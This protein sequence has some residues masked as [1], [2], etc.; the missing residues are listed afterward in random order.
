MKKP[1]YLLEMQ[2]TILNASDSYVDT[3]DYSKTFTEEDWEKIA[4]VDDVCEIANKTIC[5]KYGHTVVDDQCCKPEHRYC[6]FCKASLP[7]V[8]PDDTRE[9]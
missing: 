4:F 2:A 5:D 7:H 1:K 8:T 3:D 6:L 9:L